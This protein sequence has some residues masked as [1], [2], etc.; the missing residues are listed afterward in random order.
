MRTMKTAVIHA[1][2]ELQTKTE[3]ETVLRQLGL[4][5]TEAIRI[6]YAQ[7]LLRGGLPFAVEIPNS[8]TKETLDKSQRGEDI[9]AFDSLSDMFASWKI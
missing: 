2:I 9:Q 1:R 4:T 5:P 7:I 8:L 6:F 3:A